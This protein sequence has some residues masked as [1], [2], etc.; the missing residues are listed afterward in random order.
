MRFGA[1]DKDCTLCSQVCPTGALE[2]LTPAQRNG[3]EPYPG[4]NGPVRVKLGTA[5]YDRGRCLPW[6]MNRPCVVCEEVC[7]VSPKAITSTEVI[8]TRPDGT[9]V[10]LKRPE[11]DPAL[12]IGCG[13][14]ENACPV[15]DLPAIR[16]TPS[17]ETRS[18]GWGERDR[19]LLLKG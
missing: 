5:F 7:P 15:K 17:G 9:K 18:R 14:C 10:F 13:A 1:C 8:V 16:V 12:C 4:R 2:R 11:V 6:A 19:G 3:A